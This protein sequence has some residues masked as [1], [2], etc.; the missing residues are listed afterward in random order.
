MKVETKQFMP[1]HSERALWVGI[2]VSLLFTGLIWLT[3]PL[4]PQINFLPDTGASWYYWQLPEPTVWTRTA[5]WTGYLLHQLV[6]W[7]IIYYAQQNKLKYTKGLH[8]ANYLALAAN[9]L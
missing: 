4:L 2:L 1:N 7:G 9:A 3:A 8:R 5:V 6:A